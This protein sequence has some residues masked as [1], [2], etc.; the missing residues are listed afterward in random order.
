MPDQSFSIDV[1]ITDNSPQVLA[2]VPVAIA[3]A[4]WAMGAA[5][6]NHAKANETRVDTGRLRGSITH[7]E[8]VDKTVIGTNVEYAAAHEFGTS[9]GLSG[10]HYLKNAVANNTEEYKGIVKQSMANV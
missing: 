1:Q 4:L 7:Q 8:T 3:R 2:A 10:L 5:A 9:R 6:E